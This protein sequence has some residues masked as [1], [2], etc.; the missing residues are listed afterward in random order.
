MNS[1]PLI[2]SNTSMLPLLL[3]DDIPHKIVKSKHYDIDDIVLFYSFGRLI[4]HRVIWHHPRS[5]LYITQGDN[6]K[7]SD[8]PINSSQILGK[9]I[10]VK[11]QNSTYSLNSLYHT[12][13]VL[14]FSELLKFTKL[15][16]KFNLPFIIL[17]G[18][19]IHLKYFNHSPRHLLFDID[20]L[21]RP[22]DL[23]NFIKVFKLLNYVAV[24]NTFSTQVVFVNTT[25]KLPIAFDVH[26]E[27][28]IAF[29]K[30]P[31]LNQLLPQH[32]SVNKYLWDNI[33]QT[34]IEEFDLPLLN[35]SA[36]LIYLLIHSFH[37]N[38]RGTNRIQILNKLLTDSTIDFSKIKKD[39]EY[40]NIS[41]LGYLANSHHNNYLPLSPSLLSLQPNIVIKFI[42]PLFSLVLKPWKRNSKVIE[43]I[44]LLALVLTIS[45]LNFLSKL[46]IIFR[47]TTLAEIKQSLSSS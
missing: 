6:N 29:T 39:L 36:Q 20:I 23:S 10:S 28:A 43:R 3:P 11:R 15:T 32:K 34:R 35:K 14:Y 7:I 47:R 1:K 41:D 45:P 37:H 27:P 42:S 21:I 16:S 12:Q 25:Y 8:K 33:E 22:S 44:T 13:S 24:T 19:P 30:I 40:L 31:S 46:R 38:F 4:A 26:L 9:I 17:K 2:L 5:D 18:L